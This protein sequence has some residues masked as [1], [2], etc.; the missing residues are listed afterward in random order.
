[1][2]VNLFQYHQWANKALIRTLEENEPHLSVEDSK[3]AARLLQHIW[4]VEEIFWGNLLQIPHGYTALNLPDTP[5]MSVM[6]ERLEE[7]VLRLLVYV[8]TLAP[9]VLMERVPFRFVDGTPGEMTRQGMLMHLIIHGA[10]HRGMI[11]RLLAGA[12]RLPP[13]DVLTLFLHPNNTTQ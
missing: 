12:G 13:K 4:V 10:Y 5:S 2:L 11:G 8:E 9:E 3:L 6:A 7:S 1:M